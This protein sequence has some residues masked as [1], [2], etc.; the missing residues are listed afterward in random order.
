LRH[1]NHLGESLL[2]L[3]WH[4]RLPVILQSEAA[5]CGLACLAMI[6]SYHGHDV[7]LPWLRRRY[8]TSLKGADLGRLIEMSAQLGFLARPLRLELRHLSKLNLPCILHWD[9]NHFVVLKAVKS[10][11]VVI[12]DPGCG[13]RSIP[14]EVVSNHFTGVALEVKPSP[15]FTPVAARTRISLR[16][17]TGPIQGLR[18]A[19]V[20][21]F[22]LAL[23]LEVLT[24]LGPFYLQ[25]ILDQVLV[26]NDRDLLAVLGV[27]SII[28]V[29][30]Q[31][32]ISATR[33]WI[34]AWIGATLNV[35]WVS[36]V[37]SHLLKLPIEFFQKRHIGD[38]V[39]RF[40]SINSVQKT[41]TASFVTAILD[42]LMAGLSAVLIFFYSA[43]LGALV[44][45][46]VAVYAA[47]RW[48]T[49]TPLMRAQEEQIVY[50]GRQQSDFLESVRGVQALKLLNQ[51]NQRT[52]R[53]T[54]SAV[55][56]TNRELRL[57]RLAITFRSI[58]HV[59]FGVLRIL[60]I[61]L[62]ARYVL[63][64]EFTAGMLVA[65]LAYADLFTTRGIAL[66]DKAI[67]LR[68]LNLHAVRIADIALSAPEPES[69]SY[70]EAPPQMALNLMKVS[71]RYA[72]GEP[73]VLHEC[74]LQVKEGESIAIVG[75]SGCGKT[76][77]AKVILGLLAPASGSVN[78]G[79]RSI[80]KIGL[81]SYRTM[82]AAVMQDDQL[83]AGSIADNICF[84]DSHATMEAIEVAAKAASIHDD[85]VA[86]PMGYHTLVGD[87]GSALSG[88]Q[89]QR[90]FL[91]RAL[92]RRPRLLVLDE[93]T[94]HLD[95]ER[96]RLVNRAVRQLHIT[97]IV[98]AHRPET[99][100]NADR[101]LVMSDGHL[102]PQATDASDAGVPSDGRW[103]LI[104]TE[105]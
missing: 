47:T 70:E 90:I 39:S 64:S 38:I 63:N 94:S 76:T 40:G 93:A 41:L 78:I 51:Q 74:S 62:G 4:S 79:D 59:L 18:S 16:A 88:G 26:S 68:M 104:A 11:A 12:H 46:G 5:E 30:F 22:A 54:N 34:V 13:V 103:R 96:E 72:E 31:V 23:G 27:G 9:L 2:R 29:F 32:A 55:E 50:S 60:L 37:F 87:M 52:A 56:T 66:V 17:L 73:W 43:R 81:P 91:A 82:V 3:A 65:V 89:K 99:V 97:R 6:G 14:M 19:L 45:A 36:N 28:S 44:S 10:G 85:I 105:S 75:P 101:V 20:Q 80:Y 49:Y 35:Q 67:E 53:Y 95:L 8:S 102:C 84:F 86:M 1:V 92:F 7:D 25:W 57:E 42:G 69:E 83:F 24:L 21:V 15:A 33:S 98:I 61:W 77:L 48:M 100:A 58:D 71:F